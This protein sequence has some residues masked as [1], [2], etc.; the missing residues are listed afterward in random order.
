MHDP[1]RTAHNKRKTTRDDE[2][3]SESGGMKTFA[4][5]VGWGIWASERE[6]QKSIT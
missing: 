1:N 5:G 4:G 6:E 3:E 2:W